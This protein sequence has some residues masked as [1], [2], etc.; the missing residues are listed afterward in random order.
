VKFTRTLVLS[1]VLFT[2]LLWAQNSPVITLVT[3]AEGGSPAIA[4]NTWVVIYGSDLSPA[5]DTRTWLGSDFINNQMPARLDGV[6]VTVNGKAAYIFYISPTQVNILTPPDAMTGPVQIVLTNNGSAG[7]GYTAQAQAASPSFFMINGGPY[8]IAQHGADNSLVG[9]SSLFAGVTTPAVPGETVVLYA[10]GCGPISPA[11]V[12]GASSQTGTLTPLPVVTIG[13]I[14]AKV[15]YAGINGVPGLFQ[16]NVIVPASAPTGDV[17]LAATCNGIA[18]APPALITI[19]GSGPPPASVTF[20]VAPGGND[21]W[22]GRLPAPNST[23]TDG[24]FATF[25]HARAFVQSINKAG[26]TQVNVQF[27]GG[28]Y[29]LPAT[30]SFTAADSGSAATQIVYQNY[31]GESPV[32]SGGVRLTNWTSTGGNV[33]KTPLPAS[34]QYFENLFYNGARRLRPRLGGYLGTYYRVADTVYLNSP[35]PPAAAPEANCSAYISGKGWECFDRFLYNPADPVTNAWK[36]LAPPTGNACG[37]PAGNA[38]PTGDIEL[39]IFEKFYVGRQRISCVDTA[40]HI[41]YLTGPTV[42]LAGVTDTVG[43][44]PQHR[45]VIENI[46]DQ[47]TQPGQ[48]FLDRSTTPWTLNYLAGAGENPNTDSVIMPQLGQILVASNLQ[49]VTFQGLSFEH[50]NF[51]VPAVGFDSDDT[52]ST[53]AVSFQNSQHITFDSGTVA[54]TSANGL[55]FISCINAQSNPSCVSRNTNAVTANNVVRNSAFYDVGATGIRVGTPGINGDSNA[56]V[57]QFITVQ[58]NVVAGFGRV[59]PAAKGIFQGD[60]H[61]NIYTHNDV[62]DGYHGAISICF[63]SGVPGLAPLTNNITVS[64]NHVYNLIQ[65]IMNDGG[66]I[67]FRTSTTSTN[68]PSSGTG[69]KM[70]NNR[71]HDVSDSSVQD[72]DGYGGDGLYIDDIAGLVDVENNLVYRVSG[73]GLDFSGSR[74]GPNQSSTIK[75]NIFAFTRSSLIAAADPYAQSAQFPAPMFFTAS[76]NLFYFDR[77]SASSP[78]FYAQ[79]GCVYDG[80]VAYT[81]FEQWTSNLYWRTDGGFAGDPKAFHVLPNPVSPANICFGPPAV[82][83][84]TNYTFTGWQKLGEDVQSVVQDPGFRNPAYPADDYS[85]PNGSPG[86]G[87]VPF[88]PTQSG[89]TNPVINPPAVPA[90]FPTK[91]FNPATDF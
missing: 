5:G 22:S 66:S 69:N 17:T 52:R 34:T 37:Q 33:W 30:E 14:A 16:F 57:P 65:G 42:I 10:N 73:A 46:E 41:V 82:A 26:L 2:R 62:Y 63:C 49:Y 21:F 32:I 38:A 84:W 51:T 58:N 25:D 79:G 19:Q 85:L 60:G 67:Y 83:A 11:V 27:R 54:H 3:N 61:D 89:R 43:F 76:G 8:V 74:A 1:S 28:T 29:Y 31:P 4:P 36:N 81:S 23:N 75:N 77:S 39:V 64:F 9:P 78:S 86:V 70:L 7:V 12:N 53:A 56:N 15:V 50:D 59:F 71:I 44:I 18:T 13:G 80:G 55:E 20:Y 6:S 87:F 72:A 35:A 88:D 24:P 48:W 40:K 68:P 91:T 45:Y 47:L 90:T